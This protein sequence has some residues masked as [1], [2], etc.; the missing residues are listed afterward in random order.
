MSQLPCAYCDVPI[1][2]A[3][4][5]RS[6]LC[7]VCSRPLTVCGNY[8]LKELLSTSD[9]DRVYSA[10]READGQE[11]AVK[12]L[13][14]RDDDWSA[15]SEFERV[16]RTLQASKNRA[17]PQIF[18][19][20]RGG[21]GR[22]ILVREKCAGHTLEA[23]VRAGQRPNSPSLQKMLDDLLSLLVQ[24]HGMSPPL[25]HR[26][27][28]AENILFRDSGWAPVLADFNPSGP[29]TIALDLLSLGKAMEFAAGADHMGSVVARLVDPK[30]P[31]ASADEA[32]RDLRRQHDAPAARAALK[33]P[34]ARLPGTS[35]S[36]ST[37]TLSRRSRT[38]IWISIGIFLSLVQLVRHRKPTAPK[39]PK[40]TS[41][42]STVDRYRRE[43]DSGDQLGCYNLAYRYENGKGVPKD[44]TRAVS[45]YKASC[46]AGQDL[47][48]NNLGVLYETG[49]GVV[50]D[51]AHASQLYKLAC[52]R[53]DWL[54]CRNLGFLYSFGRGVAADVPH[55]LQL[56][57]L[58]CD[59]D[60]FRGCYNAGVLYEN[61]KGGV[62]LDFIKARALYRRACDGED[63]EGCTNLGWMTAAG[64]GAPVDF[65]VARLLYEKACDHGDASGC[66]DLGA[67]FGKGQG[68]AV[69]NIKAFG[70]YVKACDGDDYFGCSNLGYFYES[71]IGTDKDI[72]RAVTLYQKSCK[73][74]YDKAC[75]FACDDGDSWSCAEQKRRK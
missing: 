73:L 21:H 75:K 54:A 30:N 55:A 22:L 52:D 53:K 35:P 5:E 6:S 12:V 57:Q 39:P 32:L 33:P 2:S 29:G 70:Y 68:R 47:A 4:A 17:V 66:N 48:C 45:L 49:N 23:R 25:L 7:P 58:A 26:D 16:G 3:E 44:L 63:W 14:A 8:R 56:Y 36:S 41:G 1:S 10:V 9:S 46:D 40:Q 51:P 42:D 69:D 18:G 19:W 60:E 38:W 13:L 71:G 15:I 37:T 62:T 67:M 27:I 61:G 34:A 74:G 20:E 43:C 24:L 31:Y 65:E 64:S 28:R 72:P 50:K 59:H 11:V